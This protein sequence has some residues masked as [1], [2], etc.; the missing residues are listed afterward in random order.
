MSVSIL[1]LFSDF[2]DIHKDY[3]GNLQ[4]AATL[5]PLGVE[6]HRRDLFT[7]CI[8]PKSLSDTF[9]Y[10]LNGTFV[11]LKSNITQRAL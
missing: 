1:D 2:I 11:L 7:G 10:Y 9:K 6:M 4:A 3:R 8:Q 5:F